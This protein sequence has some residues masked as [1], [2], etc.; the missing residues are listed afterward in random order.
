M[1]SLVFFKEID[2]LCTLY[3]NFLV[4][5]DFTCF[6]ERTNDTMKFFYLL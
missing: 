2:V 6:F 3:V 5:H 1:V 4:A